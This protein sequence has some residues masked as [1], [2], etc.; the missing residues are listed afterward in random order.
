MTIKQFA[1][2]YK[3][4]ATGLQH[5]MYSRRSRIATYHIIRYPNGEVWGE[6]YRKRGGDTFV[7][8]SA[9]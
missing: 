6:I 4:T 5:F 1:H 9:E 2:R 8:L 7:R 3:L